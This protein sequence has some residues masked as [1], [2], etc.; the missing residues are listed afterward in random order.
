MEKEVQVFKNNAE[1][2]AYIRGKAEKIEPI[3]TRKSKKDAEIDDL[4][5][6]KPKKTRKRKK[7][8]V[9]QAE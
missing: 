8:D 5:V 4:T 9:V 6:E 7:K 3:S 1:M 2:M